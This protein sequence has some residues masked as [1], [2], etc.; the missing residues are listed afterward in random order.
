MRLVLDL[1]GAQSASRWRG[2]G[3]YSLALAQS[4]AKNRGTHEV[5]VALNGAF[6]ESIRPIRQ[7]FKSLIPHGNIRVWE[8]P[9]NI[10]ADT[11]DNL[12]RRQRAQTVYECFLANLAPDIIHVSSMFEGFG[13]DAVATVPAAGFGIPTAVTLYD[14]IPL[15]DPDRFLRPNPPLERLYT[16]Q[17]KDLSRADLLLAIS[18]FTAQDAQQR[19]DA[20]ERTIINISGACSDVFEPSKLSQ[21]DRRGLLK[22]LSLDCPYILTSGTVEPHK[23]LITLMSAFARLPHSVR[24][25]H[26]LAIIGKVEKPQR[27]VLGKIAREAGL[28]DDDVQITGYITDEELV[29]LYTEARLMVFPSLDEGFGL[30]PLEAMTCGAPTIGSRAASIPEVIGLPEALFD[31]LNV[32]ELTQL[33]ERALEDEAFRLML[34]DHAHKQ[35][36]LFS[37][38]ETGKRALSAM[39]SLVN[40]KQKPPVNKINALDHCVRKMAENFPEQAELRAL[41]QA[42]AR[43]FPDPEQ[44]PQLFVDI[45]EL[46]QRDARTGIQ[47]VTRAI[48]KEL[49][50]KPPTGFSVEPVYAT[51]DMPGYRYARAYKTGI[52]GSQIFEPDEIID[53]QTGD[54]FFG[55]D[56]QS[57]IVCYQMP[58]LSDMHMHGVNVQFVV[59]DTLPAQFPHFFPDGSAA[60][61][62]AW[63]QAISCFDG[64]IGISQDTTDTFERWRRQYSLQ[65]NPDFRARAVHLGAD[66]ENSNPSKGLPEDAS[67]VLS[68][69]KKAPSFL[70][71]GTIEPRK[72]HAQALA[73]F[74]RLWARGVQASLVIVGK[75]GWNTQD[76]LD[77]IRR[78]P[79]KGRQL[80]W[81]PGISDEYLQEI[82][83]A[84]SC[85]LAASEAE[86]FGLPLIEAAQAG[87]PILARDM[88]VFR[89]VAGDHAS[90]FQGQT[91]EALE[92]GIEQWLKRHVDGQTVR[93]EAMQWLTW[94][95]SAARMAETLIN[96]P[97]DQ[98]NTLEKNS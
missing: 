57:V 40:S 63:M 89:E 31:P 36:R 5:F 43:S 45:S 19:L 44:S 35:S 74:E 27:T 12:E 62:K 17:L 42:L 37:W 88:A 67:A 80:F 20:G 1:Q 95:E 22:R 2:I 83:T 54:V 86:G 98:V 93:S 90:Y 81:L 59:Y 48:L 73:A 61:H 24:K 55:L 75:E 4:I 32:A 78:H 49:L 23:N 84:S 91:P 16:E 50:D 72:G 28:T 38:N 18:E 30:P 21:D 14:L 52:T 13:D 3:R 92:K 47:R 34:C 10:R 96:L 66:I 60:I 87:I 53:F 58:W 46:H 11:A 33:I 76:T 85:L 68:D 8:A 15:H 25:A 7:A 56:L 51:T 29:A 6:P 65:E 70:M 69:I 79:E 64:I 26:K 9:G 71:V 97:L 41:S 39:V 77:G 94:S 82:Y